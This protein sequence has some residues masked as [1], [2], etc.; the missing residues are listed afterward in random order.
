MRAEGRRG[1]FDFAFIDADKENYDH[2]YEAALE[3]V[4]IGG[5]IAIDNV[6]W[7]GAVIDPKKQDADTKALRALNRKLRDDQRVDISMLPLGD[8][9]TLARIR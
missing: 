6:L 4:R 3:L 7:S 9:L 2:Y 8:G 5:V 1:S